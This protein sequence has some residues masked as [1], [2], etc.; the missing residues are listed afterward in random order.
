MKYLA[1]VLLFGFITGMEVSAQTTTSKGHV[2]IEA[3]PIAYALKGYSVHLGYQ[4]NS[5]RY[6]VGIFGIEVPKFLSENDDFKEYS[7]GFG[8]KVDYTGKEARGWFIG[9]Q[10]DY[11][12]ERATY[13]K[14]GHKEKGTTLSA[15]IRGGYRIMFS[16]K[17]RDGKGF[18]ITPWIGIDKVF[19]IDEIVFEEHSYENQSFRIFPTVHLGWRF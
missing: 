5:F 8:L 13:K 11:T 19:Q 3:D 16:G 12:F 18:Y 15:G 17:N 1:S 2:E 9:A 14:N 10:S 7:R 4:K 6:D